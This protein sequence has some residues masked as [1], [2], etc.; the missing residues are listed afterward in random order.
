M[1]SKD[2][3]S[4]I[5]LSFQW[6]A[7]KCITVCASK[8]FHYPGVESDFD[9]CQSAIKQIFSSNTCTLRH[10][11]LTDH[12]VKLSAAN[13]INWGRLLP[14]IVYHASSYLDLARQGVISVG[15]PVDL[16]VPTGNFGNILGAVYAKVMLLECT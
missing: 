1:E 11:L 10:S 4:Q 15:D 14:Q 9:F 5:S 3:C 12:N 7:D 8:T 16:C 13:S 2:I 6:L